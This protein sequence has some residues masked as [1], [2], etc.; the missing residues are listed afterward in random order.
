MSVE[1]KSIRE[2]CRRLEGRLGVLEVLKVEV[3]S[4]EDDWKVVWDLL[5]SRPLP[6]R[7]RVLALLGGGIIA[8]NIRYPLDLHHLSSTIPSITKLN[9]TA[10][11]FHPGTS[12]YPLLRLLPNLT[13]LETY[14]VNGLPLLLPSIDGTHRLELPYLTSLKIDS[15]ESQPP[16]PDLF[17]LVAPLLVNFVFTSNVPSYAS[18]LFSNPSLPFQFPDLRTFEVESPNN[19]AEEATLLHHLRQLPSSLQTLSL[20]SFDTLTD[21]TIEA[22]TFG[23]EEGIEPLFPFLE[24][25]TL[26][27]CAPVSGE[28]L[29]RMV[30][31][32]MGEGRQKLRSL[33]LEQREI[34]EE[35]YDWL[36]ENVNHFCSEA[37]FDPVIQGLQD[38]Y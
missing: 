12:L 4:T 24:F 22:L 32:R 23:E 20:A 33:I 14:D 34:E 38:H 27:W 29:C 19:G 7:L 5:E 2:V 30:A 28:V 3:A 17:S 6:S 21:A 1:S 15:L 36:W 25:L 18:L 10:L 16:H 9:L 31:S 13:T 11:Y 8:D 35:T 26:Q 37:F